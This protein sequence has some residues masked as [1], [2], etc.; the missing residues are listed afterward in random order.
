VDTPLDLIGTVVPADATNNIIA[1]SLKDAGDTDAAITDNTLNTTTAG[2]V[3]VT[4]TIENGL[5][6]P[7]VATISAGWH[8]T[9]LSSRQMAACGRGEI[10]D[11]ISLATVR[12]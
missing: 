10:I 9:P 12:L 4:A 8:H 6:A 7:G 2:T 1:W 11:I 3:V 5:G